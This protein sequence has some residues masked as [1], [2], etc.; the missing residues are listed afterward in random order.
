MKLL[1]KSEAAVCLIKFGAQFLGE[2]VNKPHP[3][4]HPSI[5][6]TTLYHHCHTHLVVDVT[7]M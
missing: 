7:N 5:I 2:L 3:I 6:G 4:P 1:K